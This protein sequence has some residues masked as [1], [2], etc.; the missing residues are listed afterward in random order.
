M[1]EKISI[2]TRKRYILVA[3][4][5]VMF[6]FRLCK[7]ILSSGTST[8]ETVR[9]S[10]PGH[11][12]FY[13]WAI[14]ECTFETY[15]DFT[16]FVT[17]H[18]VFGKKICLCESRKIYDNICPPNTNKYAIISYFMNNNIQFSLFI[19]IFSAHIFLATSGSNMRSRVICGAST[20]PCAAA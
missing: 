10:Y 6:K 12:P 13:R 8:D 9:Q 15:S 7:N 2:N 18:V 14:I 11:H 20:K 5:P 4:F 3:L 1:C 19:L 16:I 17:H